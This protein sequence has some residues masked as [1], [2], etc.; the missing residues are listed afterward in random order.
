MADLRPHPALSVS[1]PV[2]F[3]QETAALVIGRRLLR[4]LPRGDG[5][6]VIVIPGFLGDDGLNRPLVRFLNELGYCASGW[7]LGRNLGPSP[8][9][10]AAML[11]LVDNVSQRS[12][13]KITLIGH[14][15]GGIY[16]RE[17]SRMLPGKVRQVIS[18]GSPFSH[19]QEMPEP[20]IAKLFRRLNPDMSEFENNRDAMAEPL[21][22]PYT[23]IFTKGDGVVHWSQCVQGNGCQKTENIR[24]IGS[25][26]G[27][28]MNP[29]VRIIIADR[30]AQPEDE[31]QRFKHKR[32]RRLLIPRTDGQLRRA[33]FNA[34]QELAI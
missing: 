15:L 13:G 21:S 9:R 33:R 6:G 31:W 17:L 2:R 10:E 28:T 23:S 32:W 5:H 16:A 27:L 20:P 11:E 4:R 22:V 24:V 34:V 29:A 1:E 8:E 26:M 3:L 14:S 25:H 18:L 7:G 30:L 12:G 19:P